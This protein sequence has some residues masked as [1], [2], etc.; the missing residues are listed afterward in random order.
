MNWNKPHFSGGGRLEV[1]W[2]AIHYRPIWASLVAGRRIVVALAL[3]RKGLR[4]IHWKSLLGRNAFDYFSTSSE[5][6]LR[7]QPTNWNLCDRVILGRNQR[8]HTHL[9][10]VDFSL[11]D[12]PAACEHATEFYPKHFKAEPSRYSLFVEQPLVFGVVDFAMGLS[13]ETDHTHAIDTDGLG[14]NRYGF[15]TGRTIRIPGHLI[16]FPVSVGDKYRI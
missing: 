10:G 3:L 13:V 9:H 6:L 1:A 4:Q 12:C 16:F 11:L 5:G 15:V 7:K 8:R 2:H 14:N